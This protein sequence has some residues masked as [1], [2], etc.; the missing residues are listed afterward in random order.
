MKYF[1][2]DE[3]KV[4]DME[5]ATFGSYVCSNTRWVEVV[6]PSKILQTK[7]VTLLR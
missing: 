6:A 1:G 2:L 4:E 3:V 7:L 5:A